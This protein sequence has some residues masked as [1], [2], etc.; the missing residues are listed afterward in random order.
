MNLIGAPSD[1]VLR[2]AQELVL[3][4]HA[5]RALARDV[6]GKPIGPTSPFATCWCFYGALERASSDVSR[7]LRVPSSDLLS[8]TSSVLFLRIGQRH[9][10]H[11]HTYWAP[12]NDRA[13]R[14]GQ[15]VADMFAVG[16]IENNPL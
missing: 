11:D 13:E 5:K 14:T 2:R 7:D 9:P 12:W 4:G 6:K 16:V 15:D 1:A 10:E 3:Q 8:E